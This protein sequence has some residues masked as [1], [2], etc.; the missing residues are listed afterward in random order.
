MYNMC[1]LQ[2]YTIIYSVHACAH[3]QFKGVC[4]VYMYMICVIFCPG[5]KVVP[6]KEVK[7]SKHGVSLGTYTLS[8]VY[9][10]SLCK[11]VL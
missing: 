1:N 5:C 11:K 8:S 10:Y 6:V 7:K 2:M 3:T 9:T 4:V